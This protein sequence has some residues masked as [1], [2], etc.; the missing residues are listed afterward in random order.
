MADRTILALLAGLG[1]GA[2]NL[3]QHRQNQQQIAREEAARQF[4]QMMAQQNLKLQ[5]QG[6]LLAEQ[7]AETQRQYMEG[8]TSYNQENL[9][10]RGQE[11]ENALAQ[12]KWQNFQ[13]QVGDVN[14]QANRMGL[15]LDPGVA[16]N[17]VVGQALQQAEGVV[18]APIGRSLRMQSG[19]PSADMQGM[20][21]E[22][23][24]MRRVGG[25]ATFVPQV[26][27]DTAALRMYGVQQDQQQMILQSRDRMSAELSDAV[28]KAQTQALNEFK[29]AQWGTAIQKY[30]QANPKN[31]DMQAAQQYAQ[32]EMEQYVAARMNEASQQWLANNPHYQQ[33]NEAAQRIVAGF[34]GGG[35][36]PV[37]QSGGMT[38]PMNSRGEPMLTAPQ[39][40]QAPLP[41]TPG[42]PLL[43]DWMK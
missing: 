9:K 13:T 29:A 1:Q 18:G 31:P 27:D 15:I 25:R 10:L 21:L 5:Q 36:G 39:G 16:Q 32:H 14:A 34:A 38:I 20:P 6:Q 28:Q 42:A 40:T 4:A 12:Q 7:N 19:V 8:Q 35:Q 17:E 41:V 23:R 43:P 22:G 33:I 30:L 3:Y 26:P 2:G 37:R 11:Q 24:N